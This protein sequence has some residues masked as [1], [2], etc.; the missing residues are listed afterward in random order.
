[1]FCID[2]TETILMNTAELVDDL[3]WVQ[4]TLPS[5]LRNFLSKFDPLNV[6]AKVEYHM[7]ILKDRF[8]LKRKRKEDLFT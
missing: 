3:D 1:M 7:I 2:R 5:D 4:S 8:R 6:Q